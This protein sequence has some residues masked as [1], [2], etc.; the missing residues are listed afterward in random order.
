ML[1]ESLDKTGALV[2]IRRV[3]ERR[4]ERHRLNHLSPRN[5]VNRQAELKRYNI[6][7]SA[8]HHLTKPIHSAI[9]GE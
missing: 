1:K 3:E 2:Y 6:V 4:A 9:L 8:S 7:K 5:L